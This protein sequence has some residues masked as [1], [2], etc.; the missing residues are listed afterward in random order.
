MGYLS[1]L[2]NDPE[3]QKLFRETLQEKLSKMFDS[4]EQE[5]ISGQAQR[6]PSGLMRSECWD[7]SIEEIE[8]AEVKDGRII[9][10]GINT[11]QTNRDQPPTKPICPIAFSGR[12]AQR[13]LINWN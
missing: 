3:F 11:W 7:G 13:N 5:I 12:P 9:K 4:I 10:F 1:D 6:P 2:M 8:L